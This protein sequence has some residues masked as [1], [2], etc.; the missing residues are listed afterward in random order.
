MF[1]SDRFQDNNKLP[2]GNGFGA[3]VNFQQ[4]LVTW[5]CILVIFGSM[6]FYFAVM[7]S[8][9]FGKLPLWVR[10]IL[11]LKKEIDI[12][13]DREIYGNSEVEMIF[14]NN[15]HLQDTSARKEAEAATAELREQLAAQQ[16]MLL[17]EKQKAAKVVAQGG[18]KPRKRG[19]R[20]A[21]KKAKKGFAPT[22]LTSRSSK[23][24]ESMDEMLTGLKTLETTQNSGSTNELSLDST[25][26][27]TTNPFSTVNIKPEGA[28]HRQSKSFVPHK[29][30]DGKEYY[31]NAE[32]GEVTWVLPENA[33]VL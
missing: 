31:E 26:R 29:S 18:A 13:T 4:E 30:S 7:Y 23:T 12:N 11:C 22:K 14:Q 3:W 20:G 16:D 6:F 25:S 10:K 15:P 24:Q 27:E 2:P 32:T 1:E 19:G 33:V 5:M 8:E 9:I 21:K 17:L 28:G